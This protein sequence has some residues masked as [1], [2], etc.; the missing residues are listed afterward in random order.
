LGRSGRDENC[1]RGSA[2]AA[3]RFDLGLVQPIPLSIAMA[4][5]T[6]VFVLPERFVGVP[7]HLFAAAA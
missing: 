4:N 3:D 5:K 6:Q 7:T 1:W 2:S